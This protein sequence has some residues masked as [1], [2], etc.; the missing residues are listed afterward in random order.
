M[1]VVIDTN[2]LLV[3]NQQHSDVSADCVIACIGVLQRAENE[4]IVVLDDEFRILNE[5]LKKTDIK[6]PKRPGDVFLKWLLRNTSNERRVEC[7]ALT[8]KKNN[9]F[10]PTFP[11]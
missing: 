3:A 5:Y 10:E 8:E 9:F 11:K 1:K 6:P 2:V 4:G 7:V